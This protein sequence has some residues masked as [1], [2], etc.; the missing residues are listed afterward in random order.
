MITKIKPNYGRLKL[1]TYALLES[2]KDV[3][4]GIRLKGLCLNEIGIDDEYLIK[5]T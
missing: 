2:G 1:L 4:P 3:G 5:L